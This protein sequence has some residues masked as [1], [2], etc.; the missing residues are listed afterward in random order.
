MNF[1]FCSFQKCVLLTISSIAFCY[2]LGLLIAGELAYDF[3]DREVPSPVNLQIEER[4]I[5]L[6]N[7]TWETYDETINENQYSRSNG[8]RLTDRTIFHGHYSISEQLVEDTF[9]FK[10][11]EGCINC[12]QNLNL[13]SDVFQAIDANKPEKIYFSSA[14]IYPFDYAGTCSAMALD[15]LAR[16]RSKCNHLSNAQD[17]KVCVKSF[18]PFYLAN[19]STF[20]SRQ[21]AYNTIGI[22]PQYRNQSESIK[23]Q[24]MQ[25]LANYHRLN[26]K[27]LTDTIHVSDIEKKPNAFK[28]KIAQLPTGTYLIRAILPADNEKMEWYGHTMILIKSPEL[29]IYYDNATGAEDITG[30]VENHVRDVLLHWQIPEIRIYQATCPPDGCI[31][32]SEESF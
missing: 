9:L 11:R 21:A 4:N 16:F 27:P 15:F 8:S 19:R 28:K 26:I 12:D 2:S 14:K 18:E 3:S 31:N 22:H 6:F 17:K 29:S 13:S 5:H 1:I 30:N 20:S 32:L 25:S 23:H 10:R 24:K 7:G